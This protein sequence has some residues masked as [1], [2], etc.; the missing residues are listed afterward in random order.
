MQ[1]LKKDVLAFSLC[2]MGGMIAKLIYGWDDRELSSSTT[3]YRE[4][5]VERIFTETDPVT[6]DP[7]LPM[8]ADYIQ[9]KRFFTALFS[10]PMGEF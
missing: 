7:A 3:R 2:L 4:G 1:P 6:G 10:K 5:Y 8:R 9:I